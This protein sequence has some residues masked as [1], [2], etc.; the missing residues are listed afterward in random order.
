MNISQMM[1]REVQTCS[2]EDCLD[3]V[4]SKLWDHDIGSLPVVSDGRVI[5]MITDRDIC[6]AAYTQGTPL[7][8][9]PVYTAMSRVVFS[10]SPEDSIRK[11]EQIMRTYQIRRLPVVSQ[12][13]ELVG[14]ISLTDLAREAEIASGEKRQDVTIKEVTDTFAAITHPRSLQPEAHA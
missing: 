13:G 8:E 1:N 6:M 11:A 9:I 12:E 2:V 5:G 14:I 7:K 4:A 3:A 10:C